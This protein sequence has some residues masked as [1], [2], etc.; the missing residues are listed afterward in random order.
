MTVKELKSILETVPDDTEVMMTIHEWDRE[1]DAPTDYT[2]SIAFA[3]KDAEYVYYIHDDDGYCFLERSPR[4]TKKVLMLE[5]L[6]IYE[7]GL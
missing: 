5:S 4:R 2:D 7:K 3:K 6:D 1:F